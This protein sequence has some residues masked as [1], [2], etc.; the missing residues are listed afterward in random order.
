MQAKGVEVRLLRKQLH[1]EKELFAAE[2]MTYAELQLVRV[3]KQVSM[4]QQRLEQAVEKGDGKA[5][6]DW[7]DSMSR[8]SEI[9]RQLA[10]RP[11]PGS[12]KPTSKSPRQ[13]DAEPVPEPIRVQAAPQAVVS[14]VA[15]I[16]TT[17]GPLFYD[18]PR[19]A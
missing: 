3:R 14:P 8:L 11:M 4:F 16:D 17:S 6:R 19:R 2:S 12:L 15:K 18:D 13:V 9:E 10:G 7:T 1:V 5:V